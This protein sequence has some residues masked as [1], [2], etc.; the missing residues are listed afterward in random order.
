M[1]NPLTSLTPLLETLVKNIDV[2][3]AAG[4]AVEDYLHPDPEE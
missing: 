2:L 3:P 1:P 4:K